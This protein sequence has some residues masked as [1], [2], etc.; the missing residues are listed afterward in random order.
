MYMYMLIEQAACL[1][2]WAVVNTCVCVLGVSILSLLM[3]F[4]LDFE[5]FPQCIIF[6]SY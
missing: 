1:G 5:L 6:F 3:I 4:L 2:K